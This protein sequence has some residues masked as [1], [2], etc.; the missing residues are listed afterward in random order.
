MAKR[1]LMLRD[2]FNPPPNVNNPPPPADMKER[3]DDIAAEGPDDV[4]G[5]AIDMQ[6][7]HR[8]LWLKFEEEFD[9]PR[10]RRR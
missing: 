5:A 6:R 1:R 8:R 2:F 10:N 9:D 3:I 4:E 7:A